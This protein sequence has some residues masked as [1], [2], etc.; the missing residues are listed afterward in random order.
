MSRSHGRGVLFWLVAG[1]STALLILLL[2]L[3]GAQT[4][5]PTRQL[6]GR[7]ADSLGENN[8]PDLLEDV[9]NK[10]LGVSFSVAW[11]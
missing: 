7:V 9:F 11:W 2:V 10:T 4:L 3:T 6:P 5:F 8:K 1:L